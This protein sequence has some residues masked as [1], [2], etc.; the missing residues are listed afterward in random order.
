MSIVGR[1]GG[2]LE[3][4]WNRCEGGVMATSCI[5]FLVRLCPAMLTMYSIICLLLVIDHCYGYV[6]KRNDMYWK[7]RFSN[8]RYQPS[9]L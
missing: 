5:V 7:W 3:L 6:V 4:A 2:S 8:Y 1:A 9:G